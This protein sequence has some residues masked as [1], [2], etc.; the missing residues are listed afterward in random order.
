MWLP[1]R[2]PAVELWAVGMSGKMRPSRLI[3]GAVILAAVECAGLAAVQFAVSTAAQAQ[4]RDDRYPFLHR[5]RSGS[6][7]FFGDLFGNPGGYRRAEPQYEGGV[8]HSHAPSPRKP[9]PGVVPTTSIVVIG[10]GM[11]DW[12][13]YGL[14]DAFAD[15]PEVAIDRQAKYNS[16]LLRY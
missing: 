4:S 9:A 7:G 12:L 10:D 2:G 1:R 16:G 13:A 6:G 3:I 11:A 5:Q 8:E 14:E 15:Q